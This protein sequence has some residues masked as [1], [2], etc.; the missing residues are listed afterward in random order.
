MGSS[1]FEAAGYYRY[2]RELLLDIVMGYGMFALFASFGINGHFE[3]I[4]HIT[5][6]ISYYSAMFWIR[7]SPAKSCVF[8][9]G[10]FVEKLTSEV[11]LA[12]GVFAM[13]SNPDDVFVYAV[14]QSKPRIIDI[15]VGC[16]SEM[17]CKSIDECTCYSCRV[18]DVQPF[19]PA[20]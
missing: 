19:P 13:T 7:C 1:C 20:C 10:R 9:S 6:D 18:P 8:A 11:G 3:A 4:A 14:H 12:S 5:S 16:V 15:V 2:V 17:P